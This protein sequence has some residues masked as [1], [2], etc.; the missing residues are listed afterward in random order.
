M[1][2]MKQRRSQASFQVEV[3]PPILH[4][5]LE[6]TI[7]Q[8]L[9]QSGSCSSSSKETKTSSIS[10]VGLFGIGAGLPELGRQSV[11]QSGILGRVSFPTPSNRPPIAGVLQIKERAPDA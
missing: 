2:K 11:A 6:Y 4:P 9:I 10:Q 3:F 8:H 7:D 1:A 5:I